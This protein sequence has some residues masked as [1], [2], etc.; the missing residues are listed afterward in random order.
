V[1]NSSLFQ[2]DERTTT[3]DERFGQPQCA[4]TPF[5]FRGRL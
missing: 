1:R 3:N 2:N 5:R 4:R